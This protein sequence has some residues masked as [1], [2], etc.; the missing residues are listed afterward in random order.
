MNEEERK[1]LAYIAGMLLK[2][3]SG[4]I[5]DSNELQSLENIRD[6]LGFYHIEEDYFRW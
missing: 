4:E 1:M 3:S 6:Y 2:I 5:L